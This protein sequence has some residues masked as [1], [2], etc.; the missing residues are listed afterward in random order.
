MSHGQSYQKLAQLNHMR[1][2]YYLRTGQVLILSGASK[3]HVTVSRK[4]PHYGKWLW[5]VRGRLMH[6]FIPQRGQKGIDIV[7]RRGEQIH[8]SASGVVVYAGS[9][10]SGFDHLII[11]KHA[12]QYLTTYSHNSVNLVKEGQSVTAGQVIASLGVVDRKYYAMHFEIRLAGKPVNPLD[13]M[14]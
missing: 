10:F 1:P 5:P 9:G 14:D 12:K 8:A 11:I 2:P 4:K 3:S 7:G 6:T 13:Y